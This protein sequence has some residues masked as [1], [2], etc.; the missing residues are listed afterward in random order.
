MS[1]LIPILDL[2]EFAPPA[3]AGRKEEGP[4]NLANTLAELREQRLRLDRLILAAEDYARSGGP[5]RGRPPKWM[6]ATKR[7]GRPPGSK[8]K[9][10]RAPIQM[11]G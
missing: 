11:T 4:M 3:D 6:Q 10:L 2:L 7:R 9:A 1:R 5:R 8:N